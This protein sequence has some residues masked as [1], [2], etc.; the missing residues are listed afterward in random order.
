MNEDVILPKGYVPEPEPEP[1]DDEFGEGTPV[2]EPTSENSE[3]EN[4]EPQNI[5]RF[6]DLADFGDDEREQ[7]L[8]FIAQANADMVDPSEVYGADQWQSMVVGD[9][10]GGLAAQA[11]FAEDWTWGMTPSQRAAAVAK[12]SFDENMGSLVDEF[13]GL[14]ASAKDVGDPLEFARQVAV[15]RYARRRTYG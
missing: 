1:V 13:A 9:L 14:A 11:Q 7:G 12:V 10:Y 8:Q 5:V 2:T 6:R 4:S 15:S 3:P